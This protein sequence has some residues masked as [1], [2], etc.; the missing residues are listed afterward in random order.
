[1]SRHEH[2]IPTN[3][4]PDIPPGPDS[5]TKTTDPKV[6]TTAD[7]TSAPPDIPPGPDE[8]GHGE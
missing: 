1:M 5:P 2:D 3:Q 6:Q 7:T 8:P 4:P